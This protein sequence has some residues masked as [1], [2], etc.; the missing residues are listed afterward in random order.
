MCALRIGAHCFKPSLRIGH[1]FI[2]QFEGHP[3][4]NGDC[5]WYYARTVSGTLW[6]GLSSEEPGATPA[7]TRGEEQL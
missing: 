3:V 1:T 2:H 4:G 6:L 5:G 7:D